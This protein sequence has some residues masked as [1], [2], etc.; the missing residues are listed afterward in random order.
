M[1]PGPVRRQDRRATVKSQIRQLNETYR[2]DEL[3]VTGMIRD[4]AA[5]LRS[6]EI[7]A[8][9]LVEVQASEVAA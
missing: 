6:F 9:A 1:L 5:R 8:E 3:M 7:V 4:H 2:P